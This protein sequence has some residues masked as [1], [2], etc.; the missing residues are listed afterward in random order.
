MLTDSKDNE[1]VPDGMRA[2]TDGIQPTGHLVVRDEAFWDVCGVEN[3]TNDVG[4]Y[5]RSDGT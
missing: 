3:E 5:R 1:E 4:Q 2:A